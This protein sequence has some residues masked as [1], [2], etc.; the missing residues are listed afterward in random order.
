MIKPEDIRIG[1]LVMISYGCM[2]PN[3]TMCAVTEIHP[4]KDYKRTGG[5]I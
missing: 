2:F 4:D 5:L 3:G 1:D